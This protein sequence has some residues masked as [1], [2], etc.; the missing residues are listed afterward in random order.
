VRMPTA[1]PTPAGGRMIR[2]PVEDLRD[3]KDGANDGDGG[4]E[5]HQKV[6][7]FGSLASFGSSGCG[8]DL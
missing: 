3:Q 1:C 5:L 8:R 6:P 7:Q 4:G 2:E